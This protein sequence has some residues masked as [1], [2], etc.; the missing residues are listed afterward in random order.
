MQT[1]T[2]NNTIK[3]HTTKHPKQTNYTNTH[4]LTK[5]NKQ[6]TKQTKY[7]ESAAPTGFLNGN[8]VPQI[9]KMVS[10]SRK[11]GQMVPVGHPLC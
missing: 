7:D 6:K 1:T 9:I 3:S 5:H 8:S 4:K 2:K 10:K 11:I